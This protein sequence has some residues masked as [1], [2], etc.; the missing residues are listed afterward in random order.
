MRRIACLGL[1]AALFFITGCTGPAPGAG[2]P[3]ELARSRSSDI[4]Q[5]RYELRFDLPAQ[6]DQPVEA[7]E[8]V[9]LRLVR[10]SDIVL[11]FRVE[12]EHIHTVSV[13]GDK[14]DVN[15][16]NE[17]IIIPKKH[18][19]K[20]DNRIEIAFTAGNQSLNRR[21]EFLY[22]LLVPDRARTL[23][24]CFDQPDMKARYNLS[25][26][27][28]QEWT[29][30]SNTYIEEETTLPDGR[31]LVRFAETEPLSTY[32]FSFVAGRFERAFSER[33]GRSISMYYRETDPAKLAQQPDIFSLVFDALDYMEDYTGI[34]YPFAKYDFIVLPDFQYGGMEHTGA[35]LYNDRRIFL[36][37][38]PTTAE[39]LDRA[40]LIAHETV[41]MWF[42]DYVTMSWFDDVWTKEVFANWFAAQIVRPAFPGVNHRLGDLKTYYSPAYAED[43]TVGS[44]A[45]R[46]PLDNLGNAGLIYCNIIYDKAP[47]AMDFLARK[48]G[49]DAFRRGLQSY[50]RHY[51]YGNATWRDLI[52]ELGG[53]AGFDVSEWSRVWIEEPGMPLYEPV[54]ETDVVAFRQID[55]FGNGNVWQQEVSFE[56]CHGGHWLPDVDGS[57]YGCFLMSEDD[58]EF[59]YSQ[60]D[61]LGETARMGV[62]MNLYENV[63]R[64]RIDAARFVDWAA[65]ALDGENNSLIFNSLLGYAADAVRFPGT[66][67]PAL[68]RSLG[69]IAADVSRP[70]EMRLQAFR[71]WMNLADSP[72]DCDLL[73]GIWER[74]KPFPSLTLSEN[75]YTSLSYQLMLRFPERYEG[76][77][78]VQR[79]RIS[80]PDRL[81][82]FDFIC[83]AAAP[84]KDQREAFFQ[85]L[86][87]AENRRPESRVLSALDL[88]CHPLRGEEAASYI[89]PALKILP[90]IQRTGDIFFPAS[91]CRRIL[92]PQV[93]LTAKEEVEAFLASSDTLHPLLKTKVL[94][95]AGWLLQ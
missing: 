28:P 60:W 27:V 84:E 48:M 69:V 43:R 22:T 15:I 85:S 44:N 30:V 8:T 80:N 35:T 7:S 55:P 59:C 78:R 52:D 58:A 93:S 3:W 74:Q 34:P 91:W 25:L 56:E 45:I 54:V 33:D 61:R 4:G 47:V 36:G 88:L 12:P 1:I 90:E 10:K 53:E 6:S 70:H 68:V 81:A 19:V 11:D 72:G 86:L 26:T 42:G 71:S 32:L 75:D 13:N 64:K 29:A 16:V 89:A 95:A 63:W 18:S 17:H 51:G 38:E 40:Q 62:L 82:A 50:L 92:G 83:R 9:C 57:T 20:G 24:P 76:I 79:S 39:L 37:P 77:C 31:K 67:Q 87:Q 5:V 94:Q 66:K 73:Y 21:E 41:H 23:F 46:R 2:V 14:I 65:E 49:P